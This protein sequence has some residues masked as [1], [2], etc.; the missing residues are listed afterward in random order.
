MCA[1]TSIPVFGVVFHFIVC[2]T[3]LLQVQLVPAL[4][5]VLQRCLDDAAAAAAESAADAEGAEG[6]TPAAPSGKA[7]AGG[8]GEVAAMVELDPLALQAADLA[9]KALCNIVMQDAAAVAEQEGQV[10]G[11][12]SYSGC[13]LTQACGGSGEQAVGLMSRQQLQEVREVVGAVAEA[14]L[15]RGW[16]LELADSAALQ[17]LQQVLL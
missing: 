15:S 2:C 1:S 16:L 13:L 3:L 10:D 8:G 11:D 6:D 12:L 9:L 5:G 17:R 14:A 7:A 4:L